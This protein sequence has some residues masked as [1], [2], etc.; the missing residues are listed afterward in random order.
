MPGSLSQKR[1]TTQR[2]ANER[3][4]LCRLTHSILSPRAE[5]E[6]RDDWT[7]RVSAQTEIT[8]QALA[9]Q[10][11]TVLNGRQTGKSHFNTG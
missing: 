4:K 2:V 8:G 6:M 3:Q 5:H 1:A 7:S 11:L 10:E 9:F